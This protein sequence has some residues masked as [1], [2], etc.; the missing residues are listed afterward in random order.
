[1]NEKYEANPKDLLPF[2]APT[3]DEQAITT[4]LPP[5]G[6]VEQVVRRTVN[7]PPAVEYVDD[8][9][10]DIDQINKEWETFESSHTEFVCERKSNTEFMVFVFS[11][12]E[13]DIGR[14]LKTTA[15]A[16]D[17]YYTCTVTVKSFC[18]YNFNIFS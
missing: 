9:L 6:R 14:F 8:G 1:M 10:D 4:T 17:Y 16:R 13:V 15:T 7:P 11:L 5:A 3:T 12:L 18:V 2:R